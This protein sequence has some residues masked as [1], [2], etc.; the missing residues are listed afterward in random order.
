MATQHRL[1]NLEAQCNSWQGPLAA[2]VYVPLLL[3]DDT[4]NTAS[5]RRVQASTQ[6]LF[7]SLRNAA[8]L[9]SDTPLVAMIDTDLLLSSS[10]ATELM[11]SSS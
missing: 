10:L 3:G 5:L 6:Q 8:L 9:A 4:G 7:K 11:G 2:A 1:S